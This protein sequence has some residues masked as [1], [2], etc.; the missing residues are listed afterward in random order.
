TRCFVFVVLAALAARRLGHN[1]IVHLAENG[2]MAIHLPL[3]KARIGA[4]ST[5]TAHPE[6]LELVQPILSDLLQR[7]VVIENPFL[8]KTKGEVVSILTPKHQ[9][10]LE[11]SISCWKRV[12]NSK[13]HCGEC[14]PCII[15][16]ISLEHNNIFLD[17]YAR[18]LF[19]VDVA[20]LAADDNG[21]R[22]LLELLGFV[23]DF[24]SK[25]EAELT[26]TYLELLN[27]SF[28]SSKALEL[29]RRFSAETLAVISKYPFLMAVVS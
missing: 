4:F 12:M 23:M 24:S 1:R 17:E 10:V 14:I 18:D 3:S 25:S 13:N 9:H 15:R 2:Q 16:R 11:K 29:Y 8:Y 26:S 19:K 21:K 7:N 20:N 6:F 28:D 5:H 22:N 27:P